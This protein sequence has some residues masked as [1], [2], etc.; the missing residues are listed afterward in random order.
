MTSV[1]PHCA[2]A[3]VFYV[4]FACSS[5][6]LFLSLI[7]LLVISAGFQKFAAVGAHAPSSK[8]N[9]LGSV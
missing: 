8:S 4:T 7:L 6:K 9:R 3:P 1:L 5:C 2:C